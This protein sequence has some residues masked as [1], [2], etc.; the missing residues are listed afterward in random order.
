MRENQY[1]KFVSDVIGGEAARK[2]MSLGMWSDLQIIFITVNLAEN[3][4]DVR[5]SVSTRKT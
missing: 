3:R 2:T 1:I 4:S 5:T